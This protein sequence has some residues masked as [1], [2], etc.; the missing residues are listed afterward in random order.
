MVVCIAALVAFT[1]DI[2][3]PGTLGRVW[4]EKEEAVGKPGEERSV[5]EQF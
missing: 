5:W 1:C 3:V 2:G 4:A